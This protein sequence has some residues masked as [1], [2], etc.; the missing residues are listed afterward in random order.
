MTH[1]RVNESFQKVFSE[2]QWMPGPV[3]AVRNATFGQDKEPG[4]WAHTS[5]RLETGELG[6]SDFRLE[7]WLLTQ[8]LMFW[9]PHILVTFA[10][11]VP[12]P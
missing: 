12:S 3:L 10:F 8:A 7:T 5:T 6:S 1:V 11:V 9:G 2:Y 4:P